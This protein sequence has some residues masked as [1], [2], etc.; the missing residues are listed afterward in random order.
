MIGRIEENSYN[1]HNSRNERSDEIEKYDLTETTFVLRDL[2]F[3]KTGSDWVN[4]VFAN[5][6]KTGKRQTKTKDIEYFWVH[7]DKSMVEKINK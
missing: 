7:T 4:I 5:D 6:Q 2:H 1:R 3:S